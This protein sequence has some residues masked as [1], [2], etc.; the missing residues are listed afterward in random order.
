MPY[1]T[2][3]CRDAS[4]REREKGRIIGEGEREREREQLER[5]NRGFVVRPGGGRY[6]A[7]GMLNR[8]NVLIWEAV[9]E[10]QL[11]ETLSR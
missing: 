4:R 7:N 11:L 1:N 3:T 5:E 8:Q 2:S 9:W 6:S 10:S